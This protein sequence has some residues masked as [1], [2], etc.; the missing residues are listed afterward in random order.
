MC[1]LPPFPLINISSTFFCLC[2]YFFHLVAPELVG[3][4]SNR[5]GDQCWRLQEA[6]SNNSNWWGYF[7]DAAGY[8]Q[9]QASPSPSSSRQPSAP[10]RTPSSRSPFCTPSSLPPPTHILKLR[11]CLHMED[12]QDSMCCIDT[13]LY[14]GLMSSVRFSAI[15]ASTQE[16]KPEQ[17]N[18]TSYSRMTPHVAK[19]QS[20][21]L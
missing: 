5:K 4:Q 7:T 9:E 15:R 11:R 3:P 21:P 16:I 2:T 8:L 20:D 12:S 17:F 19:L 13:P 10:D 6:L 14:S 18:K 1:V